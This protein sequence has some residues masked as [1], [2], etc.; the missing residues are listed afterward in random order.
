MDKRN[1]IEARA[2]SRYVR[3]SDSLDNGESEG[4]PIGHVLAE[5]GRIAMAQRVYLDAM[6]PREDFGIEG[7]EYQ[8]DLFPSL[9]T[10]DLKADSP[11]LQ[12]LRKP[13]FQRETNHWS[14]EQVVTFVE[15]FLDNEVIPS[16]I[17]W[18][19]A[20]YIFAVDGGHRISALRAWMEDDYGDRTISGT[21]YGNE[22][23]RTQKAIAAR[24]RRLVEE[25]IGRFTELQSLV[26]STGNSAK[27]RRAK[28]L[29]TRGMA[30]QW[31]QGSPDAAETSFYKINTQGTPLDE[32]EEMLIRNRHKPI[33]I[34]ARAIIRAGR[35]HKYW[36]DFEP[37][38]R[39]QIEK[40]ASELFDY[41]F[42]PEADIPVKTL[43]LPLGGALSPVDALSVLVEFLSITTGEE[44]TPPAKKGTPHPRPRLKNIDEYPVDEN[45]SATVTVLTRAVKVIS[46]ITGNEARSL[47]LHPAV[48]FYNERGRHSRFLFLAIVTLIATKL[49]NN[50]D[51][52]FKKFTTARAGLEKFLV[53]NKSLI[54]LLLQNMSKAQ[55]VA[56]TQSLFEFLIDSFAAGG[57]VTAEA[58]IKQLGLKGNI[59]NIDSAQPGAFFTDDA[60]SAAFMSRA[61]NNALKCSICGGY[62]DPGKSVS[63][64]H[65]ERRRDGG[66]GEVGNADLV[67]PYCNTGYKS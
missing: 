19:S 64:D 32:I 58:A 27:E 57:L 22:L 62:L 67:H 3:D 53:D 30:V 48:Y 26:S 59:V 40:L 38:V 6:I 4:V 7:S 33:A 24:T 37:P 25:R 29:G 42:E 16:L 9:R 49:R 10:A 11:I 46:R 28:A 43:D 51:Q 17:L 5:R 13:D 60:K 55:R 31:V 23:S 15:S 41:L 20:N 21:F 8:L 39:E 50:D 61:L 1:N 66:T 2:R 14:P 12:L 35:G 63:Y 36:L 18:K 54:G 52:F 34:S 45:G 65:K 44:I 47:G 56:S